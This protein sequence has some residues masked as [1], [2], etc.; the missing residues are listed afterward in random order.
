MLYKTQQKKNW[1]KPKKRYI[2]LPKWLV[3]RI[4]KYWKKEI[5][6][7]SKFQ[8]TEQVYILD[9]CSSKKA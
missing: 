9:L 6:D 4:H 5:V 1:N 2:L 7:K 3:G 8:Y